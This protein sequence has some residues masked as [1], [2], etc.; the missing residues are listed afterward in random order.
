M[1]Q[2]RATRDGF[3]LDK[4]SLAFKWLE[5][6]MNALTIGKVMSEHPWFFV[7]MQTDVDPF[8]PRILEP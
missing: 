6:G 3:P 4:N 1:P 7:K 8:S 5:A 2:K